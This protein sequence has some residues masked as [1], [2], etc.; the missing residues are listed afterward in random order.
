MLRYAKGSALP[1][2]TGLWQ[3][4][5]IFGFLSNS[6][7]EPAAEPE[8]PLCITLDAYKGR[9]YPAPGNSVYRFNEMKAAL[10][11]IA[12]QWPAILPPKGAVI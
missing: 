3:A 11:T 10:A 7:L 5:A 12:E 4:A 1:E 6:Q 9:P 8:K 2:A